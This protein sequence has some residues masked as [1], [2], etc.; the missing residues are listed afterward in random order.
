MQSGLPAAF[1]PGLSLPKAVLAG[2]F[3]LFYLEF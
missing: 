1:S 3:E 2:D